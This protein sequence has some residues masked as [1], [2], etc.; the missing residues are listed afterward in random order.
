MGLTTGEYRYVL[1]L[2]G[3]GC[4]WSLSSYAIDALAGQEWTSYYQPEKYKRLYGVAL[5]S[6]I[7]V[8]QLVKNELLTPDEFRQLCDRHGLDEEKRIRYLITIL[9]RKGKVE[10]VKRFINSL[11]NACE[12]TGHRDILQDVKEELISLGLTV[13]ADEVANG[14]TLKSDRKRNTHAR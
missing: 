14:V 5:T 4:T 9:S 2:Y 7:S 3:F 8:P 10:Y 11:E 13:D 1:K 6:I 12:H